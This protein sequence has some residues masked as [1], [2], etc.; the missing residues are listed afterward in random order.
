MKFRLIYFAF[1]LGLIFKFGACKED[2][3]YE[4]ELVFN[5]YCAPCHMNDGSGLKGIYPA[6]GNK[7]S[8][9][10]KS[11]NIA[12]LI[13]N[14]YKTDNQL[15]AAMPPQKKLSE[16]QISNIVNYVRTK[17]YKNEAIDIKQIRSQLQ[18][19]KQD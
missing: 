15:G 4:G 7:E 10:L 6:L 11:N 18:D 17:F 5:A 8:L 14:G 1:L 12:C 2:R 3:F 16:V 13:R 19:C 9:I